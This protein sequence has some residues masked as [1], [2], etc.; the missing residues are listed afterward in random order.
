MTLGAQLYT[1]R[2]YTQTER[3]LDYSLARVADIGY[4]TVQLS[5]IGP[6]PAE[7]VR[8]LCDRHEL[9]IVLTHTNPDRILNDTEAVIREHEVLGCDYIGIGMM[10]KKYCSP[11]WLWHFREDF[12]E[13]AKKIA[14]AGKLLM[15]H[16]HNVEFQKF[17]G[18]LVMDTLIESFAPEEMG[19]TLDTY[20]VQMGGGDVCQWI[21]KLD[22]RLPCVHLKD[23][24]VKDWEPVMAPVMEG[25]LDFPRILE[26]FKK[27]GTKHLLVE[28]DICQGS[29]FD[30]LETSF[31]NLQGRY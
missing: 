31:K 4:E 27:S 17:G 30:C 10:P 7:K 19:F 6:I 26:A 14:A 21:E 20:W 15:Y 9:R 16:N 24:A 11:E 28:Q 29:P 2:E 22:G 8:A 13:P 5:A 23:M 18:K 12:R 3:D 25:N 1:L